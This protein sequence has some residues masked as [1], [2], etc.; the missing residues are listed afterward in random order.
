MT[1]HDTFRF[2]DIFKYDP[3]NMNKKKTYT[4]QNLILSDFQKGVG[5]KMT[6]CQPFGCKSCYDMFLSIFCQI[7][8]S[9]SK[10]YFL[11]AKNVKKRKKQPADGDWNSAV[12]C[13]FSIRYRFAILLSQKFFVFFLQIDSNLFYKSNERINNRWWLPIRIAF[14]LASFLCVT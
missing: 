6:N 2:C 1:E 8:Y 12:S 13:F 3:E 10:K 9:S 14:V 11:Q 5:S 4:L 7:W